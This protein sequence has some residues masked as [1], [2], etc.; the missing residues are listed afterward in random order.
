MK[1]NEEK[2]FAI[3]NWVS[4]DAK[5]EVLATKIQSKI[6]KLIFSVTVILVFDFF[7]AS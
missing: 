1:K 7:I 2:H 4:D 3:I 5:K 6:L